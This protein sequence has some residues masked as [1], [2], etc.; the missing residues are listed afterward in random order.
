MKTS[1][2]GYSALDI[3]KMMTGWRLQR[4]PAMHREHSTVSPVKESFRG[5]T[6]N[7]QAS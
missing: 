1:S 2:L 6:C 3:I 5:G 4:L 7:R